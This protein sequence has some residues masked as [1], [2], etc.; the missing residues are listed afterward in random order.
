MQLSIKRIPGACVAPVIE[1][2]LDLGLY[3]LCIFR[4]RIA[5]SCQQIDEFIVAVSGRQYKPVQGKGF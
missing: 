1:L 2:A 5:D 3:R 4:L